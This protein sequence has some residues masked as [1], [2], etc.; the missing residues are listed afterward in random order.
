MYAR[1]IEDEAKHVAG[2]GANCFNVVGPGQIIRYP[3]TEILKVLD[4]IQLLAI[5]KIS[6]FNRC[7]RLLEIN[8]HLDFSTL[9]VR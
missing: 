8:I 7:E 5:Q 9:A 4:P 6:K 3:E 1:Y 2:L